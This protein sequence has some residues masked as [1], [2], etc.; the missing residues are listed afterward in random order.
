MWDATVFGKNRDRLLEGDIAAKFFASV[1]N[2]PQVRSLLSGEHFSVDGTLIEAWA[3]MKS[4]VPQNGRKEP[5]L[6]DKEGG[7]RRGGRNTERDFR[8]EKRSNDTHCSTT[9]PDAPAV[10]QSRRPEE[11]KLC[12]MGHLMTENRNALI[13]DARL[14]RASGRAG[15]V[16]LRARHDRGQCQTWRHCGW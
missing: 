4:F 11:A 7:H 3:S 2:L 15:S 14:T 1:L 8:G 16:L 6:P 5:H 9:D 12:Y 13:V 10:P